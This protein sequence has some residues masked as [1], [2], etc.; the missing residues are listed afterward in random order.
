MSQKKAA[1]ISN[2]ANLRELICSELTLM[3]VA[4]DV[5]DTP[6]QSRDL[7][8]YYAIVCQSDMT[9]GAIENAKAQIKLLLVKSG[10]PLSEVSQGF[11]HTLKIPFPLSQFRAIFLE[12]AVQELRSTKEAPDNN[13]F[14]ADRSSLSV[15]LRGTRIQLSEY[16]FKTLE[17]LCGASGSPV[18]RRKL[19]ELLG[20]NSGNIADVYICHLRKKL[21][22]PFGIK[23]IYTVRS[24]GYMTN[25]Q[26]R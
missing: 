25:F 6:P 15:T 21:E 18:S 1:I 13:Y 7:R 17:A 5:Y 22:E 8:G 26:M 4:A 12:G 9:T 19:T 20:A 2:D 16:E 3:N 24:K 23:I 14:Y 10:S 11:T